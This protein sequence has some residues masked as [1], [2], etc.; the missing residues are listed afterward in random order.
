M[1]GCIVRTTAEL[2]LGEIGNKQVGFV[3]ALDA[4]SGYEELFFTSPAG[5]PAAR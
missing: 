1:P 2:A 4:R 5:Q 3:R